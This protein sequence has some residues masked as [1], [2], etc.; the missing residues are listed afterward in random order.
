M[1]GLCPR[2]HMCLHPHSKLQTHVCS[3]QIKHHPNKQQQSLWWENVQKKNHVYSIQNYLYFITINQQ[4][5][6]TLKP[7]SFMQQAIRKLGLV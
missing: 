5:E 4:Y 2:Q 3:E 6:M 1:N 7:D